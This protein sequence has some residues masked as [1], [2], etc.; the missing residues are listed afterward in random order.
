[1]PAEMTRGLEAASPWWTKS[2]LSLV[3]RKGHLAARASGL[4]CSWGWGKVGG[5]LI[6]AAILGP[7]LADLPQRDLRLLFAG[8]YH[9]G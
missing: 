4:G 2:G 7:E 3:K 9:C 6:V 8:R 5:V 1:M